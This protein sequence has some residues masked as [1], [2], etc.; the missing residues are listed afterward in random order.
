MNFLLG[1]TSRAKRDVQIILRFIEK[2]SRRGADAWYRRFELVI[3]GISESPSAFGLAPENDDHEE[4]IRQAIFKT[5][6]GLAYRA[7]FIV[8]ESTVFVIHVRGP[9]QTNLDADEV[10]FP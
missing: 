4:T 10:E 5:R 2:R 3:S 7:I 9:G 1:V 8:R 6:K